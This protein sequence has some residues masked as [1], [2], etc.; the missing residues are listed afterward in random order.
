VTLTEPLAISVAG[1]FRGSLKDN[2]PTLDL[3]RFGR[4]AKV[5]GE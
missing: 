1:R 2:C 3:R 4:N 5:G